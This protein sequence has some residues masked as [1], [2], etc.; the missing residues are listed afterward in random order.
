MLSDEITHSHLL[1][2]DV[3]VFGRHNLLNHATASSGSLWIKLDYA[4]KFFYA[5]TFSICKNSWSRQGIRQQHLSL[6]LHP[7]IGRWMS[8]HKL[9]DHDKTGL[10]HDLCWFDHLLPVDFFSAERIV[11]TSNWTNHICRVLD[12]LD[13]MSM[14]G[15]AHF[16]M[17]LKVMWDILVVAFLLVMV[18]SASSNNCFL[19]ASLAVTLKSDCVWSNWWD[20]R[21]VGLSC[22]PGASPLIP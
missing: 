17:T 3:P 5:I 9:I 19:S 1:L 20:R 22:L 21:V 2:L 6:Q 15:S 8:V 14:R 7:L 18:V 12:T 16:L 4:K 10:L 11:S 13:A